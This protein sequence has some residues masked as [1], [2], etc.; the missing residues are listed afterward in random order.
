M[1]E[2]WIITLCI[3]M[4]SFLRVMGDGWYTEGNFES[5]RRMLITVHNPISIDRKDCPVIITRD[6]FL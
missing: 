1:K 3:L 5:A 4:L 6:E 2:K